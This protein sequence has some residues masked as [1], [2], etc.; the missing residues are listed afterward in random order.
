MKRTLT[1]LGLLFAT[2]TESPAPAASEPTPSQAEVAAVTPAPAAPPVAAASPVANVPP[3]PDSGAAAKAA[4]AQPQA[5]PVKPAPAAGKTPTWTTDVKPL[6]AKH[7]DRCHGPDPD[8]EE[9]AVKAKKHMDTSTF[10]FKSKHDSAKLFAELSRSVTRAKDG[11]TK[12]PA[13]D[14]RGLKDEEIATLKAWAAAG[15]PK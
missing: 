6:F 11:R 12:M 9:I 15:G 8:D 2:C 13:D 4:K 5:E 3:T 7:C 14:R 10:P 1:I